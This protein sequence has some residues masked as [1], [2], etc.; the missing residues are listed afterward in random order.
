MEAIWKI[1]DCWRA[2]YANQYF[3]GNKN[4]NS[5][6]Y[7]KTDRNTYCDTYAERDTQLNIQQNI[8][9]NTRTYPDSYPTSYLYR[10]SC[11]SSNYYTD[12]NKN[13]RPHL[14]N[15]TNSNTSYHRYEMADINA[16]DEFFYFG[17]PGLYYQLVVKFFQG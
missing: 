4:R 6:P 10:N 8:K 9:P 3:H 2:A 11:T 13:T 7:K 17:T 16:I 1:P 14:D 12:K 15:E 5:Y